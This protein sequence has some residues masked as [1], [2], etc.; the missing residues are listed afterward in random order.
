MR[1]KAE[2]GICSSD[3][4]LKF[5]F[6]EQWREKQ[7]PFS[8]CFFDSLPLLHNAFKEKKIISFLEDRGDFL[9]F[10]TF[11]SEQIFNFPL[12]FE[13]LEDVLNNFFLYSYYRLQSYVFDFSKGI[14]KS[15]EKKEIFLREKEKQILKFLLDALGYKA[16]KEDLLSEIWKY[17]KKC[18]THTLESH[19]Y[20]LRK[21]IENN[22]Q[23][24]QI[25]KN[26]GR[27]YYLIFKEK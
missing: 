18:D 23:Q 6:E 22:P 2:I 1:Y 8:I 4:L 13:N 3:E 14:L 19:I 9:L 21:K 7:E 20:Q 17:D 24:P 15:T 11:F 12:K 16:T 27:G 25:L 26:N 5:F 10:K